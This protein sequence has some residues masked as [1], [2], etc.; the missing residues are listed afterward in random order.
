MSRVSAPAGP[1]RLTASK[2]GENEEKKEAKE[3]K[4]TQNDTRGVRIELQLNYTREAHKSRRLINRFMINGYSSAIS[5][6]LIVV[7]RQT[8]TVPKKKTISKTPAVYFIR[9]T[10]IVPK[11]QKFRNSETGTTSREVIIGRR[12]RTFLF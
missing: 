6:E 7:M 5:C 11:N 3:A 9:W 12:E 10:Y 8:C 2:L 1:N 4:A